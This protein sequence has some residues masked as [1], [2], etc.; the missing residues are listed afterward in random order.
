MIDRHSTEGKEKE[1]PPLVLE[2]QTFRHDQ[3][4][5][6]QKKNPYLRMPFF[7]GRNTFLRVIILKG[8]N[9]PI[10]IGNITNGFG[11]RTGSGFGGYD[12]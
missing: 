7:T 3:A 12:G 8:L 6:V 2:I 5:N 1:N 4:S 10:V 9:I 11:R